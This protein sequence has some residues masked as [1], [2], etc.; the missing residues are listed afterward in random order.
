MMITVDAVK[1]LAVRGVLPRLLTVARALLPA[2]NH[3]F[4]IGFPSN[5]GNA[6][7]T[8]RV[9]LER[10]SGRIV[11]AQA[12][13]SAYLNRRGFM[14]TDRIVRVDK[15]SLRSLWLYVT[16]EAVFF[17][18]GLYGEPAANPRKPTINLWHGGGMKW[19]SALFGERRL[20]S[21]P[22]DF[23]LG[24]TTTWGNR[25]ADISGLSET[26]VLL[27]GYPRNDDLFRPASAAALAALGIPRGRPF[28]VWMPSYRTALAH[29]TMRPMHDAADTSADVD[30]AKKF[31]RTTQILHDAGISVVVKPHPFDSVARAVAGAM[32]VG[33]EN[34]DETG[35]SLYS[36]LGASWGL[37]TDTSSVWS[38][39]LLLDRPIGFFFPDKE[40]YVAG[41]GVFPR[42][43]FEWLPGPELVSDSQIE[44]F[45]QEIVSGNGQF[46]QQRHRTA[47]RAGLVHTRHAAHGMLDALMV[48]SSSAFAR[49]LGGGPPHAGV[50]AGAAAAKEAAR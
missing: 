35:V 32:L 7:E 41:R 21:R 30:M 36:L 4:L 18:H 10:Y 47:Q 2:L 40:S 15:A 12:P 33:D 11:W 16:A 31:E 3:V 14:P 5:E 48:R 39:Y 38:D 45:A 28:V 22:S 46:E 13:S 27:V 25:T 43:I 49:R 20:R 42:D 6:V 1:R 26:D 8:A 44:A 34:L 23:I 9:M 17:T 29:G 24:A 37:I 50:G 19:S